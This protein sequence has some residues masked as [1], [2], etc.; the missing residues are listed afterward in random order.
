MRDVRLLRFV[1]AQT[2]F[3]ALL[4]QLQV[5]R[6]IPWIFFDAAKGY[7]DGTRDHL[8]EEVA[9]MGDDHHRTLPA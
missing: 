9:I 1:F 7:F 2:A 3:H 4:A 8:I 6:I 5:L